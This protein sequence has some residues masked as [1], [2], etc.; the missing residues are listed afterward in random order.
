MPEAPSVF[1]QLM[2]V[3]EDRKLNPPER[4]YTKKLFE[5]GT[6]KI[7]A[8]I[9]E[10]ASE[11]VDAARET[12]QDRSHRSHLI[13]EACDLVYHLLVMLGHHNVKLSEIEVELTSRFG[14]SGLD[15]KA[16]REQPPD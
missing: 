10:E 4:S 12:D 5:G 11:V 2:Q 13:H 6:E 7:G 1:Q 14:I 9:I 3:I 16:A 8:K 15:E